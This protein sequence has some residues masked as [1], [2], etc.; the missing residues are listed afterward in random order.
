MS[1]ARLPTVRALQWK[2]LNASPVGTAP[3]PTP[4]PPGWGSAPGGC[5]L[6]GGALWR[7]P[8]GMATAA[9]GAH[10]TGMHSCGLCPHHLWTQ[11]CALLMSACVLGTCTCAQEYK[12]WCAAKM[13]IIIIIFGSVSPPPLS[14]RMWADHEHLSPDTSLYLSVST[15]SDCVHL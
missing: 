14:T 15:T 11:G 2:S 12:Y 7:H 8:P 4:H 3:S 10:P 1:T 9:G 13:W 6:W 5:F